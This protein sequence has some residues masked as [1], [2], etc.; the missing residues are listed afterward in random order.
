VVLD[1]PRIK[2]IW[3]EDKNQ[4][5]IKPHS[6]FLEEAKT[7]FYDPN[8]KIIYG[9]DHSKKED[10]FIIL[11]LSKALNVLIVCHCYKE[12]GRTNEKKHGGN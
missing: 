2:F 3:D 12:Q 9:P 8:A 7:V 10:R 1:P 4:R 6:I 5:N 11:G